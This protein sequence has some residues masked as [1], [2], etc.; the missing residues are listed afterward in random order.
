MAEE[1]NWDRRVIRLLVGSR[2]SF[3]CPGRDIYMVVPEGR[4]DVAEG[5]GLGLN[6]FQ[7]DDSPR[8]R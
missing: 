8:Q 1:T 7:L 5:Q 3:S 6:A 4:S 2:D